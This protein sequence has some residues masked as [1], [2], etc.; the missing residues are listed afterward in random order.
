VFAVGIT[1]A[2]KEDLDKVW[3]RNFTQEQREKIHRFYFR[4]GFD[5]SKLS[6]GN[7]ILMSLMKVKLKNEKNPSEDE[8]EILEAFEKPVDFTDKNNILPLIELV[9]G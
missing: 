5:F 4:G 2:R 1:P 7:K 6:F 9:G 3:E 8:K